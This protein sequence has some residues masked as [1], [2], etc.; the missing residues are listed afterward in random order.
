[1]AFLVS[2]LL[3]TST[4]LTEF[5]AALG[6]SGLSTV[7]TE[8]EAEV[9]AKVSETTIDD[10]VLKGWVRTVTLFRAYLA[11]QFKTPAGLKEEYTR[12]QTEL[13]KIQTRQSAPPN[14]SGAGAYGSHVLVPGVMAYLDSQT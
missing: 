7:L 8:C 9:R 12:V 6:A 13:D 14:A 3:L 2:D 5:Q 1:M 4:R 11:A 10:S